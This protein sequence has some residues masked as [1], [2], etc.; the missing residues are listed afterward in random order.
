MLGPDTRMAQCKVSIDFLKDE[1]T[2]RILAGAMAGMVV[3]EASPG[4]ERR[5]GGIDYIRYVVWHPNLPP[6]HIVHALNG[7]PPVLQ[8]ILLDMAPVDD[9]PGVFRVGWSL[10]AAGAIGVL[11]GFEVDL[12]QR[13]AT[14]SSRLPQPGDEANDNQIG[15][16]KPQ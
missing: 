8:T 6:S 4:S 12:N 9:R 15:V 14:L 7:K 16:V 1:T 13:G 10:R 2:M 5:G 3:M 11:W